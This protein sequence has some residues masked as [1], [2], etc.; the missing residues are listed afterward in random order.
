MTQQF[1]IGTTVTDLSGFVGRIVN[2]THYNGSEWYDV[3]FQSGVAVRYPE[4]LTGA[5]K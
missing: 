5:A 1:E 3:R 4:E 2:V